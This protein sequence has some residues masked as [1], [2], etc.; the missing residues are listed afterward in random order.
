MNEFVNRS[1]AIE[2][3]EQALRERLKSL[4]LD[5]DLASARNK[6]QLL[7]AGGV[8][9]CPE[10]VVVIGQAHGDIERQGDH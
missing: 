3:W 5:R 2:Q 10:D 1:R 4:T 8:L 9:W 6:G 7:L